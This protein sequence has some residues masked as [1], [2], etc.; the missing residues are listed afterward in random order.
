MT[1]H[2][3][4]SE[5]EP[6]G[7]LIILGIALILVGVGA[8]AFPLAATLSVE[9]LTGSA[10]LVAGICTIFH[11]FAAEKWS[12][13]FWETMIGLLYIATGIGFLLNPLAGIVALT[14]M[15]GGVF[16]AEGMMRAILAFQ[17]RPAKNWGWMLFS[18]LV[19]ALLGALVIGGLANGASLLFLGMLVGINFI[20]A[21]AA[22]IAVGTGR[23]EMP[24]FGTTEA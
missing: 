10:F 6:N 20:F 13:V 16:L 1:E 22:F 21:G 14:V 19:S 11:A 5:R 8:A 12:G 23:G 18:G 4:D 24:D 3:T 2:I 17:L 15:L 7:W 9:I